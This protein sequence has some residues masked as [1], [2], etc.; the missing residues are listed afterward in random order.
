MI[1]GKNLKK[2]LENNNH[3]LAKEML[4]SLERVRD[5]AKKF[6]VDLDKLE[7]VYAGKDNPKRTFDEI[8][9]K[10]ADSINIII[11][12]CRRKK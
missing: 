8:C 9:N 2:L 11:T 10:F 3:R 7:G 6:G 4:K 1:I 12:K 5:S